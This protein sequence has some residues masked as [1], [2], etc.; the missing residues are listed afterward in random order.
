MDDP[1]KELSDASSG[2]EDDDEEEDDGGEFA[3]GGYH[4]LA[5]NSDEVREV[6]SLDG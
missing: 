6:F 4:R 1:D 3:T 5:Q 2:F